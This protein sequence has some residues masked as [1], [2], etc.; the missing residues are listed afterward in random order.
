MTDKCVL[1]NAETLKFRVQ[2]LYKLKRVKCIKFRQL[3]RTAVGMQGLRF[4]DR[5]RKLNTLI[6]LNHYENIINTLIAELNPNCHL[7]AFLVAHPILHISRSRFKSPFRGL[8]LTQINFTLYS[9]YTSDRITDASG[10][11]SRQK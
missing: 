3:H 1:H 8:C 11:S 7:L 10:L 4:I 9:G 6:F 5:N 2:K